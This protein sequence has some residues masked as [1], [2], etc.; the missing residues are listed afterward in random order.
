MACCPPPKSCVVKVLLQMGR[1]GNPHPQ[2]SQQRAVASSHE[3]QATSTSH[4]PAQLL[5]YSRQEGQRSQGAAPTQP[6]L[7]QQRLY[8]R[9]SHQ[10]TLF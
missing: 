7:P 8:P 6:P 9:H 5:V 3:Q 10:R 4:P 2:S 1:P